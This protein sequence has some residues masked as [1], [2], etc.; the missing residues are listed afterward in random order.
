MIYSILYL[1][2]VLIQ[3]FLAL[4]GL[5]IQAN[6]TKQMFDIIDILMFSSRMWFLSNFNCNFIFNLIKSD[7]ITRTHKEIKSSA[8]CIS[9]NEVVFTNNEHYRFLLSQIWIVDIGVIL[10]VVLCHC[11]QKGMIMIVIILLMLMMLMLILM[12]RVVFD[13]PSISGYILVVFRFVCSSHAFEDVVCSS[14]FLKFTFISF[15]FHNSC[16]H[17]ILHYLL[18]Y[19]RIFPK[20]TLHYLFHYSLFSI[21]TS[22]V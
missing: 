19:L 14:F 22:H 3:P 1:Y 21:I 2:L 12:N 5:Y 7:F 18:Y 8:K 20:N 10:I 6:T 13:I 17:Y 11:Y 4:P 15:I 9:N 16:S